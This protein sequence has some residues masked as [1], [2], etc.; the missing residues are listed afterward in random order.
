[1]YNLNVHKQF[2]YTSNT[3]TLVKVNCYE[4]RHSFMCSKEDKQINRC[5]NIKSIAKN[6]T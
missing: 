2:N 3:K 4:I 5:Y 6:S 1:M